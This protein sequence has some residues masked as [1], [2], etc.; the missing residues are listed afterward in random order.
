MEPDVSLSLDA[1][2]WLYIGSPALFTMLLAIL[3]YGRRRT[4]DEEDHLYVHAIVCAI[5][6]TMYLAMATGIAAVTLETGR[7]YDFG[8]YLDWSF[9]TPLLLY[10]LGLTAMHGSIS[11]K[12]VM[13]AILGFDVL[14]IGTCLALGFLPNSQQGL[15][16]LWWVLGDVFFLGVL[17]LVWTT[18]K[19]ESEKRGPV[20]ARIFKRNAGIL[21]VLWSIYAVAILLGHNA[22]GWWSQATN[23]GVIVFLDV[24][25][26]GMYG[27]LSVKG[28]Q[29]IVEA[30][31]NSQ[32]RQ[33]SSADAGVPHRA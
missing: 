33:P 14:M 28:T 1:Q 8:R 20:V 6:G 30:E 13:V 31:R 24:T 32:V 2:T 18:L 25:A 17:Y 23:A 16:I 29:E 15:K 3:F 11:R 22:L 7:I 21:T 9:T 19:T 26:K 12:G 4:E 27:L 5:A 10:G